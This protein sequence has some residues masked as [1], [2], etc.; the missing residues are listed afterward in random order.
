MFIDSVVDDFLRFIKANLMK[1][2]QKKSIRGQCVEKNE[3][4]VSEVCLVSDTSLRVKH[5][6]MTRGLYAL[7]QILGQGH[8]NSSSHC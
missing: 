5:K 4:L 1:V 7:Y 8:D 6:S 2:K 3:R